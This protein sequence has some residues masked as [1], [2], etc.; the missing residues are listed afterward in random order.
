VAGRLAG[1]RPPPTESLAIL[2]GTTL[3]LLK[4]DL[5]D[6]FRSA[7]N[8]SEL[9]LQIVVPPQKVHCSVVLHRDSQS[10][11][12]LRGSTQMLSNSFDGISGAPGGATKLAGLEFQ[13]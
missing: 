13:G 2:K 3:R 5:R 8:T 9:N 12:L 11:I 4:G 6:S 1:L 10:I 7:Q